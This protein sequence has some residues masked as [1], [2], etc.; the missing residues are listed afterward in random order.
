MINTAIFDL[1]DVLCRYDLDARLRSLS[2]ISGR[3]PEDI[4]RDIWQSGFEDR[5][6]AGHYMDADAYLAAF[7]KRL[8][9]PISREQWMAARKRSMIPFSGM[10]EIALKLKVSRKIAVLTNNVPL[11][12]ETLPEIFPQVSELFG[13]QIYFS[14]D[15]GLAKPDFELY[16]RTAARC[17]TRVEDCL[18][19]DDKLINVEGAR[20]AGMQGIHFTDEAEF[21]VSLARYGIVL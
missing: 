9:F 16:R 4:H 13:E 6:D 21:R 20:Q 18:F 19:I 5:A 17:D 14:C 10:L 15:F 2:E 7:A 1:D 11:L 8:K 3:P 12:R